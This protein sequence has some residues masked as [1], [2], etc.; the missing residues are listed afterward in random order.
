VLAAAAWSLWSLTFFRLITGIGLGA[1]MPNTVTLMTEYA[2]TSKRNRLSTL[3]FCGF[4]LGS[5]LSA[6]VASL[7][8]PAFGWRSL[9]LLGGLLPTALA[10]VLMIVLPESVRFLVC[11][12]ASVRRIAAILRRI[13]R[14]HN[15]DDVTFVVPELNSATQESSIRSLF[16]HGNAF[17]TIQLWITYFMGLLIAYLLTGWLPM[18]MREAG[19]PLAQA[20]IVTGM[21]MFGSTFGTIFMGWLMDKL[22]R[23]AVVAV[24]YAT[25]GLCIIAIGMHAQDVSLLRI[26]VFA[27][28][29]A[30]GA[31]LSMVVLSA[32]FY[33]TQYR[34]TGVSWMLGIGR[35][36]GILGASMGGILMSM[37]W[38]FQSI[39]SSLA[40]PATIAA[41]SIGVKGIHYARKDRN[42]LHCPETTPRL[43]LH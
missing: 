27:A 40:I 25:A 42:T 15:F 19:V 36:G 18:L 6:F 14:D 43:D 28:G 29:L 35:F 34:A 5:A 32:Q 9:L 7:L 30:M 26:L 22:N 21:F 24:S 4:S 23:Y 2:P 38:G 37:D 1:A 31:N 12:N 17:G 11:S 33:Q 16:L 10:L 20:A 13:S 3:M 41:V 8:I 39:I